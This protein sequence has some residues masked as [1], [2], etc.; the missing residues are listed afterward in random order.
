MVV[1]F[2][3]VNRVKGDPVFSFSVVL[4]PTPPESVG[5]NRMIVSY[6]MRGQ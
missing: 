1:V 4:F 3:L 2:I 5:K 6:S